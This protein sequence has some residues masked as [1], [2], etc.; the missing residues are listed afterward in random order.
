MGT[1]VMKTTVARKVTVD[2]FYLR[3]DKKIDT[4]RRKIWR[5]IFD[6]RADLSD[7]DVA[8]AIGIVGYELNHHGSGGMDGD[9]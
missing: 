4:L 7:C 9:A 5:A 2:A 1:M 8:M 3:M 6:G